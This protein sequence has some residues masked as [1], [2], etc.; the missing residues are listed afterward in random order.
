MKKNNKIN[1]SFTVN[2]Q[3]IKDFS[4]ENPKAYINLAS[5]EKPEIDVSIDLGAHSIQEDIF[6]VVLGISVKSSI[7]EDTQFIIDLKYAG[8]FTLEKNTED[9]ERILLVECPNMLFPYARNII[10]DTTRN[11]GY[12]PLYIS[13]IDFYTLYLENKNKNQKEKLN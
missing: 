6:E 10:S 9:K 13:P 5:T 8:R 11:G 2:A 3:Y 1:G 12:L 7:K 4:F